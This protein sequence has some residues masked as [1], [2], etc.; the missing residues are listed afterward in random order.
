MSNHVLTEQ[1]MGEFFMVMR[2]MEDVLKR[3]VGIRVRV[4]AGKV[5]QMRSWRR[6]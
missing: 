6:L 1:E 4:P 5:V 3:R 2:G